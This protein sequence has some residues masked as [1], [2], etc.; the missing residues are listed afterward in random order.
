MV[1][2][3]FALAAGAGVG[4]GVLFIAT[5]LR[6]P[7]QAAAPPTPARW[8]D[9]NARLVR[10]GVVAAVLL[11]LTRWPVVALAGAVLAFF[12]TDLF[13]M[14]EPYNRPGVISG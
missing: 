11:V 13:G 8:P 3:P 10:A 9:L 5:G 7:P 14:T 1:V 2:S 12:F 6:P 4:I